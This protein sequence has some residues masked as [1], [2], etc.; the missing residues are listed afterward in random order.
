MKQKQTVS[1]R[2][3]LKFWVRTQVVPHS[4]RLRLRVAGAA[5]FRIYKNQGKPGNKAQMQGQGPDIGIMAVWREGDRT[6]PSRTSGEHIPGLF[7]VCLHCAAA[8]QGPVSTP[9]PTAP[10]QQ[11]PSAQGCSIRILASVRSAPVC[12]ALSLSN[13][14]RKSWF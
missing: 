4:P 14:G 5:Q 12:L 10:Q 1:H 7:L 11:I 13:K 2:A 8:A 9:S 6:N 3:S